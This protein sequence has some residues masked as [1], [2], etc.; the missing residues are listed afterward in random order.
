[1]TT[2]NDD[3]SKPREWILRSDGNQH[4][5]WIKA[6]RLNGTGGWDDLFVE[7]EGVRVIE[8]SAFEAER[9]ARIKAEAEVERLR[10]EL[11]AR[12]HS[13]P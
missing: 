7:P 1:M 12:P 8:Y 13:R 4:N 3:K 6:Q 2:P 5:T 10:A 9:Q 11:N